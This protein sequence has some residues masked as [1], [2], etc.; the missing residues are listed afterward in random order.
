MSQLY[1]NLLSKDPQAVGGVSATLGIFRGFVE[2]VVDPEK[3]G[4]VQVRVPHVHGNVPTSHLPWAERVFSDGGGFGAGTFNPLR[5]MSEARVQDG[6][7]VWVMFEGGDHHLPVVIGTWYANPDGS[8]EVP[9]EATAAEGMRRRYVQKTRHGHRVELSDE[10]NQFEIKISTAYDESDEDPS[11]HVILLRE[12]DG[13]R[14][15]HMQTAG[16]SILSLQD[17]DPD[18]PATPLLKR[19]D[20][21]PDLNAV[22][23]STYEPVAFPESSP[24]DGVVR[25][26]TPVVPEGLGQKGVM[27]KT[28][29]GHV[30]TMTESDQKIKIE[31]QGGQKIEI[32]DATG[33]ITINGGDFVN[34]SANVDISFTAPSF[35]VNAENANWSMINGVFTVNAQAI[36]FV[37][38]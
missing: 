38:I 6:D 34:V 5:G 19:Y 26:A 22:G 29:S 23:P 14:G 16:G 24:A 12:S 21:H 30:I 2:N 9:V 31:S 4:R 13:G 18:D 27:L 8:T 32:D 36:N 3:R 28:P 35:G 37:Q 7:G 17:E 11:A 20:E 1:A 25:S 33:T 10:R 15:I